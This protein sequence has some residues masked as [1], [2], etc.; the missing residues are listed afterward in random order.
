MFSLALFFTFLFT[1]RGGAAVL[2]TFMTL[3]L[4]VVTTI[5][6]GS[7]QLLSLLV[8]GIALAAAVGVV[9]V[10]V[11]PFLPPDPPALPGLA[12]AAPPAP[13]K[14]DPVDARRVTQV[15][16]AQV[17]GLD[18]WGGRYLGGGPIPAKGRGSRS[19]GCGGWQARTHR[20]TAKGGVVVAQDNIL[21]HGN[22]P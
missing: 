7:P 19:R 14:P 21:R 11:A 22:A 6:S 8:P 5:G 12:P 20:S 10:W 16:G 4:T 17:R 9:F 1:A 3:G 15:G 18:R 2:G 13:Q